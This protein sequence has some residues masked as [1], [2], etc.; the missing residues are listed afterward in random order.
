[1]WPGSCGLECQGGGEMRRCTLGHSISVPGSH[2]KVLSRVG[3]GRYRTSLVREEGSGVNSG[4][5][6]AGEDMAELGCEG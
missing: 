6:Q 1:M 2:R 4:V 3:P 5:G